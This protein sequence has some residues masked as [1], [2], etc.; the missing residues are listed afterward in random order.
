[1]ALKEI[2][3]LNFHCTLFSCSCVNLWKRVKELCLGLRRL[4][5]PFENEASKIFLIRKTF[6]ARF[7]LECNFASF[8]SFFL[9]EKIKIIAFVGT[10]FRFMTVLFVPLNLFYFILFFFSCF[11][12]VWFKKNVVQKSQWEKLSFFHFET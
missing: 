1:M 2:N 6:S 5:I 12:C 3:K 8:S 7:S 10:S 9:R 11:F 4:D